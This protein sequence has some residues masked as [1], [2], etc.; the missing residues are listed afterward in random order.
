LESFIVALKLKKKKFKDCSVRS[1]FEQRLAEFA[2]NST[3][4]AGQIGKIIECEQG[5]REILRT[6]LR[7]QR[8]A[9]M[10]KIRD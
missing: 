4:V 8:K 2:K 9:A 10:E 7:P 3:I 6:E 1:N 5:V